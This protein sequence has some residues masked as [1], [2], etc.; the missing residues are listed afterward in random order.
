MDRREGRIEMDVFLGGL[1]GAGLKGSRSVRPAFIC[2][3][4][5][6]FVLSPLSQGQEL[7]DRIELEIENGIGSFCFQ[8]ARLAPHAE[9]QVSS[10]G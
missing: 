3:N 7:E 6:D 2:F 5:A 8:A 1:Y 4:P 9:A 10:S